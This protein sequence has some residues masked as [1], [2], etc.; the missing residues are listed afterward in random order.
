[1]RILITFLIHITACAVYADTINHYMNI[2]ENIPKM[3]IKADPQSQTWARSARNV[4][5]ITNET[6]AETLMQA[7]ETAKSQGK[8][9]FCLP[10]TVELTPKKMGELIE[11]AYRDVSSQRSDRDKL[12]VS[13]IA[14][15]AVTQYYPCQASPA[16]NA[17][18][19]VMQHVTSP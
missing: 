8:P 4:L 2:A 18:G 19:R 15:V 9:L 12:T 10:A 11:K 3:E 13:Q 6:V 17:I 7:N 14:W 5:T 1:M 16:A